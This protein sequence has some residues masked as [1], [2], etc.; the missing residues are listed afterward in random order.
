MIIV[1]A[2]AY[3][4][5]KLTSLIGSSV[6]VESGIEVSFL[7]PPFHLVPIIVQLYT[8]NGRDRNLCLASFYFIFNRLSLLPWR[9]WVFLFDLSPS[10]C[11]LSS[12]DPV[13]LPSD[14][15]R[16]GHSCESRGKGIASRWLVKIK[17]I[18]RNNR[19]L[20]KSIQTSW[21]VLNNCLGCFLLLELILRVD[22]ISLLTWRW[23]VGQEW[24]L[25]NRCRPQSEAKP[26]GSRWLFQ[27][28]IRSTTYIEKHY[29]LLGVG[30]MGGLIR[31]LQ[32]HNQLF[33]PTF[34]TVHLSPHQDY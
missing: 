20:C 2:Q 26:A 21:P 3:H 34:K 30:G 15:G 6:W 24:Y 1:E 4:S 28:C 23:S 32:S 13:S 8:I 17:R 9:F 27:Y 31:C 16:R 25:V 22:G 19:N 7:E 33:P 12:C 14:V 18:V 11:L 29:A 10:S 5:N